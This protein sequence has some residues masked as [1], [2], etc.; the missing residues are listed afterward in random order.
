QLLSL[1][2]I[3][4]LSL[5]RQGFPLPFS[6]VLGEARL[7]R[8]LPVGVVL[9]GA[10]WRICKMGGRCILNGG[11]LRSQRTCLARFEERERKGVIVMEKTAMSREMSREMSIRP[12]KPMNQLVYG[13][14][15]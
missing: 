14:S 10:D 15:F 3:T 1:P 6:L 11:K 9:G 5:E 12:E 8:L 13:A 7:R 4:E 2:L